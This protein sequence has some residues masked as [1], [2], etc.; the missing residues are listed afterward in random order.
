MRKSL[1]ITGASGFIGRNFIKRIES[2]KYDTIFCLSR[3]ENLV[4]TSSSKSANIK[5]IKGDIFD[6]TQY[7]PYLEHADTI[8]HFAAATGK[9]KPP[10]YFKV[11]SEGT[12]LLIKLAEKAGVNNLLFIS[13]ISATYPDISKYYYAQSKLEG[14]A[15][16]KRS[17]LNYA[18]IR[19]TI[20]I[21]NDSPLWG[22]L[23]DLSK[24]TVVPVF[25]KGDVLIQ[26]VYI[27]DLVDGLLH[28]LSEKLFNN[29]TFDFG[30]PETITLENFLR[31]IKNVSDDRPFRVVHIPLK[32][33]LAFLSFFEEIYYS[34]LPF[35]IGQLSAFRFDSTVKNS[36]LFLTYHPQMKNIDEMIRLSIGKE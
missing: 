26:P 28:I 20:V 6:T 35:N 11:N 8:I 32:S 24:M 19:P 2:E 25:G 5:F 9:Q 16:V 12:R 10:E 14:E 7:V 30:G 23:Y 29:N 36:D 22:N 31:R 18:I 4:D 33:T 3:K 15:A 27:D 21:G 34:L 13:S 17:K 1:F